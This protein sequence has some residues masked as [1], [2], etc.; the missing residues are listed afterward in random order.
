MSN[1]EIRKPLKEIR[2]LLEN[3]NNFDYETLVS[4][5]EPFFGSYVAKTQ[6]TITHHILSSQTNE[7]IVVGATF[8]S[9]GKINGSV[10][11][12]LKPVQGLKLLGYSVTKQ[13]MSKSKWV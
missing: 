7:S 8:I 1:R 10:E 4:Y 2:F 6:K 9:M 3:N 13:K 5:S 12:F 11:T